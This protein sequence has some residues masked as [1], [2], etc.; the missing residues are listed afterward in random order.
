MFSHEIDKLRDEFFRARPSASE[1]ETAV[2]K[3]SEM[4]SLEG[5]DLWALVNI[6]PINEEEL[7]REVLKASARVKRGIFSGR[8]F[9]IAPLYVSSY[10]VEHCVYCNYRVENRDTDVLRVRL[11]RHGLEDEVAYLL[12]KGYSAIELVYATDTALSPSD[13]GGHLSMTRKFIEDKNLSGVA[14][15]NSQAFTTD[16]YREIAA[17]GV[18]FV[19]LWQETYSGE[20]YRRLHPNGNSKKDF[21]FRADAPERMIE[22][23]VREIGMGILFGLAPANEDFFT[24]LMHERYLIENY[25]KKCAVLGIPRLKPARGALLKEAPHPVSDDEL[26]LMVAIHNVVFPRTLP[27]INTRETFD[28]CRE[29][30]AGGGALFTFDCSTIPGGYSRNKS[31]YQFPTGNYPIEKYRGFLEKDGMNLRMDWDFKNYGR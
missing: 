25:G 6:A 7:F 27:F 24:L 5:R 19:A 3:V 9:P 28:L 17:S 29:L 30:A 10:C 23:G 2:K 31:G 13:I 16:G 15:L 21:S 18:D 14:A 22:G 20:S 1:K 12:E 4:E 8:V 26:K 11:D